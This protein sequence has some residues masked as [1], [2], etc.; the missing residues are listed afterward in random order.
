MNSNLIWIPSLQT[1]KRFSELT[2]RHQKQLSKIV[3]DDLEFIFT[4]NSIIKDISIDDI[5]F[6][7]LTLIDKYIICV[8]IR[9]ICISTTL[10]L[11]ISCPKCGASFMENIDINKIIEDNVEVLDKDYKKIIK[12]NQ[13]EFLCDVPSVGKEYEL[14]EYLTNKQIQKNSVDNIY[15]I[16]TFSHIKQM[17][18]SGNVCD[19]SNLSIDDT[20]SIL[21][22]IPYKP[23]FE[24]QKKFIE[25]LTN[26]L[27]P[28]ILNVPCPT[29]SCPPFKLNLE[30]SNI[31]DI[32][33][34]MFQELPVEILRDIYYLSKYCNMNPFYVETL[35]PKERNTMI[36]FLSDEN[37]NEKESL[38]NS[39]MGDNLSDFDEF[40]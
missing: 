40:A 2:T 18:I 11:S 3:D 33:K 17:K 12:V 26:Q 34:L 21:T 32:L 13:F 31:N 37:K 4:L 20:V 1:Y 39:G 27:N 5:D 29:E 36:K 16:H 8:Y 25:P 9:M 24:I 38:N 15:T 28:N 7:S 30:I 10:P 6:D 23:L 19:F 35:T 14:L 22:K